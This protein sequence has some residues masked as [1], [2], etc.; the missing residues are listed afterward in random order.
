MSDE[1]LNSALEKMRADGVG[2]AAVRSF[3]HYYERLSRGDRGVL[4]EDEIEPVEAVT[5]LDELPGDIDKAELDQAGG[6][7]LNGVLGPR[8]V[9]TKAKSLLEVKDALTFRDIIARQVLHLREETAA[10]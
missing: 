4:G 5:T 3:A 7:K 10:R 2:E 1:G 9:V 6:T 8:M